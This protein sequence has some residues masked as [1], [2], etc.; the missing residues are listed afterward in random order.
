[1][2]G[3]RMVILKFIYATNYRIP[4][5]YCHRIVDGRKEMFYLATHSTHFISVIWRQTYY[6]KWPLSERGNPLPPHGLLFSISNKGSFICT[7]PQTG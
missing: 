1:M 3:V 2:V 5:S 6:G 4:H 7:I